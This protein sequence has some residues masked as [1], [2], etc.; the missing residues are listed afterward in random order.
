MRKPPS[1]L[2]SK[3]HMFCSAECRQA[4]Y[5]NVWS[6]SDEWR[7]ASRRRGVR[8]LSRGD[9]DR[10][11]KPQ[12]MVNGLLD[13]LHITYINEYDCK[14]FAIDNYLPQYNLMIEVMGDFWHSSPIRYRADQLRDVQRKIIAKDKRKHTYIE[15]SHGV[16]ILYLWESDI[17]HRIDLCRAMIEQY[18]Q[19][20]GVL[21]NYHSFNYDYCDGHLLLH[22]EVIQAY[23]ERC[24]INT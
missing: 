3:Q 14:Y 1:R 21:P 13:R 5:A 9:V 2:A 7:E 15:R 22:T 18:I 23:F 17:Y 16:Q 4:W 11:T 19:R 24:A 8:L 12:V 6:Q 20:E 10:Q